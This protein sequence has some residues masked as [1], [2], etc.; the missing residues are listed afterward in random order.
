M[1]LAGGDL[2]QS[3]GEPGVWSEPDV[4]SPLPFDNSI[5]REII[6][7]QLHRILGGYGC[8]VVERTGSDVWAFL[9]SHDIL[10]MHRV[11]SYLFSILFCMEHEILMGVSANRPM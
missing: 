6:Y 1:L 7:E 8:L 5:L 3:F 10:W 4:R 2:I 9:L 11:S